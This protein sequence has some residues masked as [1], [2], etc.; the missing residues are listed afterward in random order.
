[1]TKAAQSL[2]RTLIVFLG[3]RLLVLMELVLPDGE[4]IAGDLNLFASWSTGIASGHD[5]AGEMW[6]YPPG[7]AL[8]LGA[9]GALG[10][11][12]G[13]ILA[14]IALSDLAIL[15]L[16][17][18]SDGAWFWAIAPL[19]T[20]A[21]MLTHLDVLVALTALL[22]LTA[23]RPMASGLW[24]GAGASLKVWPIVLALGLGRTEWKTRVAYALA[25]LAGAYAAARVLLGDLPF[26]SN[27]AARGL[28]V[29]SLAAFPFMVA[30]SAGVP[31]DIVF[32]NGASE[33]AGPLADTIALLLVP[34]AVF[35]AAGLTAV[36]WHWDRHSRAPAELVSVVLVSVLLLTSR[37]LSPQFNVWILGLV[38]LSV[39]RGTAS[40]GVIVAVATTSLLAQVLYPFAYLD[41]LDGGLAGTLVQG[42]R[43]MALCA[44]PLFAWR[45][46]R[47][48]ANGIREAK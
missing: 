9:L 24:I 3:V 21:M 37:V 15:W 46:L 28:Q 1:M 11:G 13:G 26:E 43:L 34:I 47:T 4:Y 22:A 27:A 16:L 48:T 41:F 40:R 29:E 20:G 38:A 23:S 31:I 25:V 12:A 14:L 5:P 32:Q 33:V 39:A 17:R 19:F 2:V 7:F 30:A 44:L 8:L 42:G 18:D 10:L 6:Q 36:L 35:V 45:D